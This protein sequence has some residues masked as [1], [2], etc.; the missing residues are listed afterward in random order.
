MGNDLGRIATIA[1]TLVIVASLLG[2]GSGGLDLDGVNPVEDAIEEVNEN[3]RDRQKRTLV[4]FGFG[5]P[6]YTE[7][8]EPLPAHWSFYSPLDGCRYRASFN[9]LSQQWTFYE[10]DGSTAAR[11]FRFNPGSLA[12]SG[13]PGSTNCP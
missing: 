11:Y 12:D 10:D 6:S 2:C 3:D 1:S 5:E 9:I 7:Q 13:W 4:E 8:A